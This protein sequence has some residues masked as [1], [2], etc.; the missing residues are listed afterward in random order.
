M[1]STK[2]WKLTATLLLGAV[3][4]LSNASFLARPSGALQLLAHRG[5]H[6]RFDMQGVDNDTCTASR[7]HP[8]THAYLED[9]IPAIGRAFEL[10]ADMV[11]V[12]VH[13][14]RDGDFAVFHDWTLEC[15]TNGEGPTRDHSMEELRRLDIGY[16]YTAD[17]GKTFPFRGAGIGLM[18][19]LREVLVAFPGR[20]FMIN[21][22]SRTPE[23]GD[24]M[25]AY[26]ASFH[27]ASPDRLVFAGADPAIRVG[28]L[29]PGWRVINERV[30]KRCALGYMLLGWSS[31]VPSAC[32]GTII[33][34]P[35]NYAAVAWGWPDRLLARMH[36]AQTEV[37]LAGPTPWRGRPILTGIDDAAAW[38]SVPHG[39]NGGVVTDAI[40][41]VGPL[42]RGVQA[43]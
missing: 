9:T 18:P 10:G 7:I 42:A 4:F 12:D 31:Y 39:W 6:Q 15:R 34:V 27:E 29:H 13:P 19:N 26:L 33:F 2:R 21:F 35:V 36:G 37:F 41:V 25:S 11:E 14:T 20:R 40:E 32:R 1:G 43:Q 5:V 16:G 23:E 3:L 24:A 30:L 22:K 8:P 28:E 38:S 17:R